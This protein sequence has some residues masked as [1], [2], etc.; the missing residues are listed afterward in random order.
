MMLAGRVF[1]QGLLS[2]AQDPL[3]VDVGADALF[4]YSSFRGINLAQQTFQRGSQL[5]FFPDRET[6][7]TINGGK[8]LPENERNDKAVTSGEQI[9]WDWPNSRLIID[10]PAVK[11]Y[12]GKI[13]GPFQFSDGITL[14]EVSTPWISF[15][16]VSADGAPLTGKK[17]TQRAYIGAVYDARNTGFEFD[18]SAGSNPI[19]QAKLVY[20]NG[21]LPVVVTPVD[22]TISL[23][24]K[25][26]GSLTSYDFALRET[27]NSVLTDTNTFSYEGVPAFVNVL[28]IKA[29][30][31]RGKLPLAAPT[32][33]ALHVS[34]QS[35]SKTGETLA[36]SSF[37]VMSELPW[38]AKYEEADKILRDSSLVYVHIKSEGKK[39]KGEIR[40][41]GLELPSLWRGQ[42]NVA[43]QFEN[44][45]AATAEAI[46]IQPPSID[47]VL[48][49]YTKLL[50]KPKEKKF[51]A[52]YEETRFVWEREKEPRKV[53]VTESQGTMKISVTR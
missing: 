25:I 12:V 23:P 44:D 15:S 1:L 34:G 7:I 52:Q 3:I 20:D 22:F 37:P 9:I 51:G 4:S 36:A 29:Q 16:M 31:G 47:T 42:A 33:I 28:E 5:R 48:T 39:G 10:A 24:N 21:R 14:S 6:G 2:P 17:A 46:F 32:Q 43:I 49:D 35:A 8:P 26:S 40:L 38:N 18:Y 19:E 41:N 13:D 11:A 45:R 27:R 53:M 50:G 30:G